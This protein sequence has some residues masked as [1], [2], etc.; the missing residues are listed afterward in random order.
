MSRSTATPA[1][2][3]NLNAGFNPGTWV[4]GDTIND[5]TPDYR[6]PEGRTWTVVWSGVFVTS[7][8]IALSL[9]RSTAEPAGTLS[10]LTQAFSSDS[11]TTLEALRDQIRALS[12]VLW[13]T[14]SGG[15][16]SP[17]LDIAF[18][19]GR[20]GVVTG[21]TVTGG[22][23]Q[24]TATITETTPGA[25]MDG[26]TVAAVDIHLQQGLATLTHEDVVYTAQRR[27]EGTTGNSITIIKVDPGAP[28]S[29]LSISV[30]DLEIT[31]N[32]ETNGS[33]TLI[34]TA[35][36]IV[37]AVANDASAS[38]LITATTSTGATVQGA[39]S[40]SNTLGDGSAAAD[41]T[42]D[43]R[44]WA[45]LQNLWRWAVIQGSTVSSLASQETM[46]V[47]VA[48]HFRL[49]AEI[50]AVSGAGATV[51]AR[52]SPLEGGSA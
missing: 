11:T 24:A 8:S 52:I 38:N 3:V 28:S 47:N 48:N 34:S 33:S 7:N 1:E 15:A 49:Y 43:Y 18:E 44:I 17:R 46:R 14:S 29:P 6:P 2:L 42:C 37:D 12:G 31:I 9:D 36:D 16:S 21:G 19:E 39:L 4:A 27:Y 5:S 30:S 50:T 13:C 23:S 25:S 51:A 45:F 20:Y 26:V 35:Q 41:R 10:A 22:A 32:L 40:A